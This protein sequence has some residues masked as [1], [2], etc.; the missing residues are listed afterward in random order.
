MYDRWR[1]YR[2]PD[3]LEFIRER[4]VRLWHQSVST[5][6]KAKHA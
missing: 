2:F 6:G 4:A 3:E 5:I 1:P